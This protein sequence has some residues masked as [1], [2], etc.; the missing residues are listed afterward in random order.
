MINPKA[1]WEHIITVSVGDNKQDVD[2]YVTVFDG[3]Y[4]ISED[5]D[6]KSDNLGPD[7]ISISSSDPFWK[8]NNYNTSI[9]I[10]FMVGVKAKTD[11]VDYTL[12]M[13]GPTKFQVPI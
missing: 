7:D 11:N 8:N 10:L 4:P 1:D 2:L 12:I 9:G 3:R 5:Y 6:F 13:I